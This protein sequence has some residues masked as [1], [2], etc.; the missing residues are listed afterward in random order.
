MNM[1][2]YHGQGSIALPY[3][4]NFVPDFSLN[5]QMYQYIN[6]INIARPTITSIIIWWGL[7]DPPYH[8]STQ[9]GPA[10]FTWWTATNTPPSNP[11]YADPDFFKKTTPP[12]LFPMQVGIWYKIRTWIYLNDD[13]TF[14]PVDQCGYNDIYVRIQKQG[15]VL[16]YSYDGVTTIKTVPIP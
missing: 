16:E 13:Q 10:A 11:T 6:Y 1:M 2:V 15:S 12:N 7:F 8:Q 5:D 4:L 9:I 14:F 3:T